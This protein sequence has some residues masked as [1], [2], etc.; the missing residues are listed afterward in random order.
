MELEFRLKLNNIKAKQVSISAPKAERKEL[1][2][3][4]AEIEN[5]AEGGQ[6]VL[7]VSMII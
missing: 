6:F 5:K 7:V 4:F 3:E 1:L 2:L